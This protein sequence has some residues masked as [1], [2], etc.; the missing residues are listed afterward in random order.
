MIGWLLDK[1]PLWLWLL[2]AAVALVA[3]WRLFG[4]RGAI[5]ILAALITA[6]AFRTGR[7]SGSADALARQKRNDEKAVKDHERIKAE[8]DRMSDDEL[9][10]ANAPW[11][12][13]QRQR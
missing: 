2:L 6:G 13:G 9:D 8:T 10:A 1:V 11:V 5:A 7:Q 4:L 3:A 12:R